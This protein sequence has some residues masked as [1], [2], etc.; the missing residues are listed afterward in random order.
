[1]RKI[2]AIITLSIAILGLSACN[3]VGRMA[4]VFKCNT[5]VKVEGV[6]TTLQEVTNSTFP[7][8]YRD[9]GWEQDYK[10]EW[11]RLIVLRSGLTTSSFDESLPAN[12]VLTVPTR[13]G[14][15]N[16]SGSRK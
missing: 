15:D 4:T 6:S 13:C 11:R 10:D 1:M 9:G 16:T 7:S 3:T 2:L 8:W 12:T 5:K 14:Q